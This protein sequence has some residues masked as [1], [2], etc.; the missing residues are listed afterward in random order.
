M[1]FKSLISEFSCNTIRG[2]GKKSRLDSYLEF[3]VELITFLRFSCVQYERHQRYLE[4]IWFWRTKIVDGVKNLQGICF[5]ILQI[6][7]K[8]FNVMVSKPYFDIILD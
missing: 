6:Y 8:Y 1:V 2:C 5:I 7:G 3:S 4:L